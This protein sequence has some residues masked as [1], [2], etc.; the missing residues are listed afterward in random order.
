MKPIRMGLQ[1]PNFTYPGVAP[2]R[3]FET[4]AAQAVAAERAGFDA[5]FLMDHFFQLPM[6]GRPDQEMLECYTTLAALAA[7]TSTIRL[8][9]MVGGVTYRNPAYLAKAVTT[10][11]IVSGGRA[12][13]GIGAAWFELEHS[14]YG[15]DFGTFG[16]R[17]ER[18]EEALQIVK[19]MF[20]NPTTTFEGKWYQV[21]DAYNEPKPLQPGGVPVLIGGGG[22]RKTLRMVAQYADACN[23]FGTVDE[24]RH[25]MSVLDEHCK[26][27]GRDPKS[28]CRTR[29]GTLIVGRTRDEALAQRDALLTARGLRW[30]Q[31]PAEMQTMLTN[32]FILGDPAEVR[33]QTKALLDAGLD[34]M[35]FNM[36]G[37][38]D[39]R[40]VAL[41]G[42]V[43]APLLLR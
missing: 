15:Y 41:A 9:A 12:I 35:V 40:D 16:Q 36:P 23:I 29:L 21:R 13:W 11:D 14:A 17:F 20:V 43:L 25:K 1:I 33:Q 39:P 4:V 42:E 37:A 24:V 31:L 22:E 10:L 3:L 8:G 2:E 18:L 7:R 19:S 6:L 27:L 26:R 5:L 30:D 32:T 28:I 38:S 34:G